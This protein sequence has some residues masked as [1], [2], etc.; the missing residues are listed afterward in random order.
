MIK[1]GNLL[2]LI[3]FFLVLL[4]CEKTPGEGGTSRI[5]GK[6]YV[7]QYDPFFTVLEHEYYGANIKVMITYGENISP[8][9]NVETNENGEFEFIYLH[10]GKYKIT[11]YSD[12]LVDADYPSGKESIDTTV[13]VSDRKQ[14]LDIGVRTIKKN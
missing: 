1:K 11:V 13:T 6:V 2:F 7:K 5:R 3:S 8:D 14:T 10:K 12:V 9:Q 4:S